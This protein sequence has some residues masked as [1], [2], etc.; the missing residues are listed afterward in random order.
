M[1]R[2]R[3]FMSGALAVVAAPL[4]AAAQQVGK[5]PRI[6]YLSAS[7]TETDQSWVA[8]FLQRLRELGYIEGQSVVIE[9]RHA[10]GRY[11]QLPGLAAELVRLKVDVLVVYGGVPGVRA[12]SEAT[13]T[14]PIVMTVGAD[15]VGA[16]LAAGLARPGGQVTGLSDFHAGTITKRLELLKEVAPSVSRVAVLLNPGNPTSLLQLKT[17]H[18]AAPALGVTLLS[19]EVKGPDDLAHALTTIGNALPGA[20]L[21]I[22]DSTFVDR[23][24]IAEF[25]VKSRL[26]AISTVRQWAEAGLLISYGA[27]FSDLWRRAAMYVDKILKGA[28]PGDLPIEQAM[29]WELVINLKTARALNLT[30]PPSLLLRADH[31]IE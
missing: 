1:M 23:K 22:S 27:N 25:A 31:V 12:A 4:V 14:I 18:A 29:T 30:I 16:G 15:P 11:E 21:L 13:S 17:I 6:G 19:W 2:R 10:A 20:L 7:S 26:P 9:Q 24:R 28:K 8:A 3:V 5:V